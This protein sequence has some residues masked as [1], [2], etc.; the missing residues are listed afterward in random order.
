MNIMNLYK[1][2][3]NSQFI[4]NT[5]KYLFT[6]ELSY[7]YSPVYVSL[8][9]AVS[10]P[11]HVAQNLHKTLKCHG[12]FKV[13]KPVTKKKFLWSK[14]VNQLII[15]INANNLI[16]P[17]WNSVYKCLF[18]CTRSCVETWPPAFTPALLTRSDIFIREA[19]HS[20]NLTSAVENQSSFFIFTG[21]CQLRS[22]LTSCG[23][24]YVTLSQK[25]A[26]KK[27]SK[28]PL[29]GCLGCLCTDHYKAQQFKFLMTVC[30]FY[31]ATGTI[32]AQKFMSFFYYYLTILC[33]FLWLSLLNQHFISLIPKYIFT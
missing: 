17:K 24:V 10:A 1:Y 27:S 31:K 23:H 9:V 18:A 28:L 3:P 14:K 30:L 8:L 26:K 15:I 5:F 29:V 7:S 13:N 20:S 33:M 32:F 21:E 19:G 22:H 6:F 12:L 25:S 4:K 16:K 2:A 11:P